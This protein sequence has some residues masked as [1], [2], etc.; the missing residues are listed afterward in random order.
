MSTPAGWYPD[1]ATPGLQRYWDGQAWSADVVAPRSPYDLKAPESTDPNTLWIWL[2][3]LL[4]VLPMLISLFIP[5]GSLFEFDPYT[6]DPTAAM[7]ASLA[8]Y[9]S[10]VFIL[11][12]V[13]S[14]A[15]YGVCIFFAYRDH[16]ELLARGV[17]RPFHWAWAF[18]NPVYP[19]GRSVVVKR[20]TGRGLAPL[21]VT[22]AT[23][24]LSL[25]VAIV[26]SVIAFD[27]I[28]DMVRSMP[29]M[30]RA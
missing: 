28:F 12:S 1:P 8:P 21:W 3:V 20:R 26:I 11:S 19:I 2:V 24:V 4:P 17:P 15:V 30:P 13:V 10:P 18:L 16:R 22:V 14:Y 23:M 5:W 27:A 25:A 9:A 29:G 7:Q 6:T